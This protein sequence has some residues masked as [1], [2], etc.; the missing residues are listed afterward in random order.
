MLIRPS[1]TSYAQKCLRGTA[2][3]RSTEY[4]PI[5]LHKLWGRGIC[6]VEQREF[7]P[8]F[9]LLMNREYHLM[10]WMMTGIIVEDSRF[11]S[12]IILKFTEHKVDMK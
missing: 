11:M 2:L 4:K 5:I 12:L 7:S 6:G 9:L 1:G 10:P 8:S 3:E